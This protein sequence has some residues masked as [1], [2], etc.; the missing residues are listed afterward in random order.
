M[1]YESNPDE[2]QPHNINPE[3][4]YV[5]PFAVGEIPTMEDNLYAGTTPDTIDGERTAIE[6]AAEKKELVQQEIAGI[7]ASDRVKNVS[8][9]GIDHAPYALSSSFKGIDD[10]REFNLGGAVA[11]AYDEKRITAE[12]FYAGM[13]RAKAQELGD[14]VQRLDE[15]TAGAQRNVNKLA[16]RN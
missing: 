2:S 7:L 13:Q 9:E 10:G 16:S 14:V 15:V 11:G 3:D 5:D 4:L 6:R 1:S 8:V 12:Q